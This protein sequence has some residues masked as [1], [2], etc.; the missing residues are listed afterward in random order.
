MTLDRSARKGTIDVTIDTPSI[1]TIDPRLDVE[2]KSE[3]GFNVAKYP[4]M[5]FESSNLIFDG[6]RLVGAQGVLTMIGVTRPVA[7]KLANSFVATI[8]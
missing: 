8:R 3:A 5:T 6:D 7:L 2:M 1:K 4:T